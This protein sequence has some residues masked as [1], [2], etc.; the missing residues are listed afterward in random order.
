MK[1]FTPHSLRLR[2]ILGTA[3]GLV[4]ISMIYAT[5]TVIGLNAFKLRS[6]RQQM[7]QEIELFMTFVD[8]K[9]GNLIVNAPEG[10]L[11]KK[12]YCIWIYSTD[13]KLLWTSNYLPSFIK[14]IPQRWL[15]QEGLYEIETPTLLKGSVGEDGKG[16]P[17][18]SEN[19]MTPFVQY[20]YTVV[21]AHY[22]KSATLPALK[23]VLVDMVPQEKQDND[24]IWGT[25]KQVTILNLFI[26]LP[27]V[28]L[29]AQWSLRPIDRLARAVLELEASS[30]KTLIYSPPG[31]LT[32]LVD[33]LNALLQQQTTLVARYRNAL[34]DLAHSIKTPLAV[35]QS[36]FR[37]LRAQPELMNEQEPLMQEQ[38]SRISQ[39]IGYHLRRVVHG[40]DRGFNRQIHS[41]SGL[42]DP[43][44]NALR[45]VYQRKGVD[46]QLEISPELTFVGEKN[47]YL[48]V[49]G[50]IIDN[51]CKYCL[52]FVEIK[53]SQSGDKL[54]IEVG[55]DGPGV[56]A[57]RR[58]QILQRGVR[59]DTL[60]PG[61]GIG[62]AVAVDILSAYNGAIEIGES[63][64][65]GACFRITFGHQ[66]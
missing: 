32:R 56:N 57:S 37:T 48:E 63:P 9:Q 13:N 30:N 58:E 49:M 39:Q 5:V 29:V 36:S 54:T 23:V 33:N 3:I 43:L 19:L 38:I 8:I 16:L 22:G 53:V 17:S 6:I 7:A 52:E 62:L 11:R 18:A 55:D 34:G 40:P 31:E 14:Q 20:T 26:L 2:F 25:F 50:N 27:I 46:L 10:R 47:D 24:A 41:V 4:L 51:A 65:G 35:L 15:A 59:V 66:N 12:N 28:W 60:R 45:K 64:L 42:L 21:V 1:K 61:Q 44:C